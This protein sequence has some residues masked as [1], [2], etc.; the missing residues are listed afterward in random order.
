M[1]PRPCGRTLRFAGGADQRNHERPPTSTGEPRSLMSR[2]TGWLRPT[3]VA[4]A[5]CD[6]PCGI[7]DPSE[8]VLAARTVARMVELLGQIPEGSTAVADR[9]TFVRSIAVK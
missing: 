2:L 1:P 7:Y 8:A 3:T 6:I 5:H 9:N 4:R